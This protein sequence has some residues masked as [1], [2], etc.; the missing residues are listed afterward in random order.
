MRLCDNANESRSVV[1]GA[2]SGVRRAG[3]G[4]GVRNYLKPPILASVTIAEPRHLKDGPE[5]VQKE[6]EDAGTAC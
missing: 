1:R 3:P 6:H 4:C 5:N 2:G